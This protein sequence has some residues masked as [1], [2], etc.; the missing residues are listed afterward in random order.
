MEGPQ[1]GGLSEFDNHLIC[2]H[3]VLTKYQ[4]QCSFALAFY[5]CLDN[6][7]NNEHLCTET[8]IERERERV[9]FCVSCC[10]GIFL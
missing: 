9:V 10:S 8:Q 5:A 2:R 6:L 4:S 3:T 1:K 7:P